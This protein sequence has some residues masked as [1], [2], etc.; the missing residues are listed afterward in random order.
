[1]SI[2]PAPGRGR[3]RAPSTEN[4]SAP[5][6]RATIDPDIRL[7]LFRTT[8]SSAAAEALTAPKSHARSVR[9]MFTWR[10]SWGPGGTAYVVSRTSRIGPEANVASVRELQLD[11]GPM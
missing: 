3:A 7:P 4:V 5:R 9:C 2:L 8:M 10:V 6:D 1:M 11:L